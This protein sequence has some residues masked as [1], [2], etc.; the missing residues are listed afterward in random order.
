M[1]SLEPDQQLLPTEMDACHNELVIV[2]ARVPESNLQKKEQRVQGGRREKE[3][4]R[5]GE[6]E[7]GREGE[8][9]R[10]SV[11]V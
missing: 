8:S 5:D 11:C 6:R 10:E 9:G 7:R 3:R 4:E 2:T 1:S